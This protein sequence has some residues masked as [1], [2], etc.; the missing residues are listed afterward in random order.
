[1]SVKVGDAAP[2]FEL[3]GTDGTEAG[4]RRYRLT[5]Y[6]GRPVVVVFYPGDDT[7]VCTVQLTSYT[8]DAVDFQQV[9]AQVLAMS[10]QTVESHERFA[11]SQGGFAFPLLADPDK[12]VGR[13][14]GTVGPLGFYRRAAFV[15]DAEGV[16][17]WVSRS[18]TGLS[19]PATSV[20]VDAVGDAVPPD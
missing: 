6:R 8:E 12:A 15:I 2:D 17:R 10:P 16:V 13:R 11:A 1:M 3:D 7:P 20:L 18:I 19:F 9:G 4:R 14:Y 5:D